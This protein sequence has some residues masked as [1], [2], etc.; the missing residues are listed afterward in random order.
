MY[1][2]KPIQKTLVWGTE[3]WLL[4]AVPGSESVVSEGPAKGRSLTEIYGGSF[5][6]LIKFIDAHADL[7]IQVHPNDAIAMRRHHSRGKSEMWYVTGVE[8]GAYLYSGLNREISPQEYDELVE[9][10][11]ICSV[12]NRFE[13]QP[14]DVFYLPAGR[15]HAIGAGCRLAE[16][17]QC[18]DITYRIYDYGRKGLDGRP[19]QLHTEWA[20]SAIDYNYYPDCKTVYERKADTPVPLVGSK[21]FSVDLL[22]LDAPYLADLSS[23][24]SFEVFVVL[25]GKCRNYITMPDGSPMKKKMTLDVFQKNLPGIIEVSTD[26]SA[27]KP[28][29]TNPATTEAK[30]KEEQPKDFPKPEPKDDLPP[31]LEEDSDQRPIIAKLRKAIAT[32]D[33][34]EDQIF[35]K[36]NPKHTDRYGEVS[37]LSEW[38]DAFVEWLLKG[39]DRI[40]QVLKK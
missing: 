11:S 30:P 5:P 16:I 26:K 8:K 13:V 33:L 15:I 24:G 21:P 22:E 9:S 19:R 2:F 17:Q 27:P 3:S 29:K 28:E 25:D 37:S 14:G 36:Y 18:S 34:T 40:A 39:M 1:K 31:E 20:R 12:L 4:S 7:S 10:N 23:V 35:N 38:S 6:L 32:Y